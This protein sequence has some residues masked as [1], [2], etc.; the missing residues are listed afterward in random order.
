ML[1]AQFCLAC[2]GLI[3]RIIK[4]KKL[5][6]ADDDDDHERTDDSINEMDT[7]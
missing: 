7:T 4:K 1:S 6:F 2:N 3:F 5:L